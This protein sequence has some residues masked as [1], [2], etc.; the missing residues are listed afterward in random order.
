MSYELKS[1]SEIISDVKNVI[2]DVKN[3]ISDVKNVIKTESINICKDIINNV[4]LYT[5]F[6]WPIT[7]LIFTVKHD[8]VGLATTAV[9]PICIIYYIMIYIMIYSILTYIVH[10]YYINLFI[11]FII[12]ILI[13]R[14][15]FNLLKY[16][17]S[18][19]YNIP[20]YKPISD[21]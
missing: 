12:T 6:R 8:K 18:L 4:D 16:L 21:I 14:S 5:P 20:I 17:W 2:S 11:F 19:R 1:L 10:E 13:S 3:V 9:L 15:F 7:W